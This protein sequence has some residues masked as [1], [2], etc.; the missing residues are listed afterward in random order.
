MPN[1]LV[2]FLQQYRFI[3]PQD[4]QLIA[5]AFKP[6]SFK[7]GDT[8][9]APGRVISQLFFIV[10]GVLR[11]MVTNEKGNEITHY[12]LKEHQFCTILNSFRNELI[13][14]ESIQAACNADVLEIDRKALQKLYRQVPYL[15][16]LIDKITQQALI[17]KI[18]IRNAYLG[19]D[20]AERYN[21]FLDRQPE[22]ALRVS[23]ADIAS[24]LGITPQSLSRIR[25]NLR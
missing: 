22:I 16:A 3:P 10:K 19:H 21:L 18:N 13:A 6:E 4:Q 8:L 14:Q 5:E 24:Y 23:L 25:K 20:S 12:F 15:E 17:D 7:E 1:P 11:I 2:S 9:F